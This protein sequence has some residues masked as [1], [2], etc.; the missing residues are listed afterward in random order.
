MKIETIDLKGSGVLTS[1]HIAKKYRKATFAESEFVAVHYGD[2]NGNEI[3]GDI[4]SSGMRSSGGF[5]IIKFAKFIYANNARSVIITHNHPSGSAKPSPEDLEMTQTLN[6]VCEVLD[7]RLLDHVIVGI[8][9]WYS[10]KEGKVYKYRGKSSVSKNVDPGSGFRFTSSE[11]LTYQKKE[12]QT[13]YDI[14]ED[15]VKIPLNRHTEFLIYF[16][17][18]NHRLVHV[19]KINL[20]SYELDK[21]LQKDFVRHLLSQAVSDV[22]IVMRMPKRTSMKQWNYQ[23]KLINFFAASSQSIGAKLVDVIILSGNEWFSKHDNNIHTIGEHPMPESES[24]KKGAS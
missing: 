15:A 21:A 13:T 9:Y 11:V 23:N 7:I 20:Y 19:K 8:D 3:G 17:S 22:I 4:I 12:I 10:I 14:V 16:M 6:D 1:L 24:S 5:E 2:E 18:E